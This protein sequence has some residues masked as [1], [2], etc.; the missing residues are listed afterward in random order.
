MNFSHG[1]YY[2]LLLI[3]IY[4]FIFLNRKYLWAILLYSSFIFYAADKVHY[5]AI[6]ILSAAIDYVAAIYI[7]KRRNT[8]AARYMLGA[9]IAANLSIL[10]FF[11]YME[12]V[13]GDWSWIEV[14]HNI[15]TSASGDILLPLGLSFYTLQSM[16]YTIDVFRDRIKAERHFGYFA[17]Y[18]CFFPQLVAGP[19]ERASSLLPQLRNLRPLRLGNVRAGV[20]LILLGLTKKLIVA[21]RLFLI[22]NDWTANAESLAAWQAWSYG[23]L[24]FVAVYLDIAG[25][26]DIARGSARL[27]GIHL[28][29]NFDRPFAAR[30][31][32]D[33]WRRWHISLT[34]WIFDYLYTPLA[35]QSR[36]RW[37][38][39]T[40]LIF[41]FLII[42]LWHGPTWPFIAMG[43]F[44]GV[45]IVLERVAVRKGVTMPST[46]GFKLLRHLRVHLILNISGIL[47]ISPGIENTITVITQALNG[48]SGINLHSIPNSLGGNYN[49]IVI[50]IGFLLI[51]TQR[52]FF[53]NMQI[54]KKNTHLLNVSICILVFSNI[55]FAYRGS[56]GFLYFNF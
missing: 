55:A 14:R 19:I 3:L 31:I 28:M 10:F 9:S 42:G 37:A 11:K 52:K 8:T 43:V 40:A 12:S 22:L 44:N 21:D 15:L 23:S 35:R 30:S 39:H 38:R 5:I 50:I 16:G 46:F 32:G 13:F 33:F 24:T 48:E 1:S 20:L 34:S 45:V 27:F 47:F 56:D 53:N 6:L 25:Y 7:E 51:S 36:S 4:I 54:F 49:V 41:T 26:T 18:V 2:V 17:L 29:E